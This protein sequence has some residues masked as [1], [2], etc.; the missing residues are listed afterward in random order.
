MLIGLTGGIASGKSTVTKLFMNEGIP[1]V[2]ADLIAREV[3]EVGREAWKKIVDYF[4]E[5]ILLP[6]K[7]INR[8]KLGNIIFQDENKRKKLNE[9][10]HPII[11]S[12]ILSRAK[13]LQ[14]TYKRVIVDIPLLFESRRESLFDLIIVVYVD[15]ESQIKRLMERDHIDRNEALSKINSQIPL[16][17]KIKWADIVIY[18]DKTIEET[19]KQVIDIIKK[20]NG[21]V[22]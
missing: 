12:E 7:S 10:T 19:K 3:V 22:G 17:D 13:K 11:I 5:E 4:G 14:V 6:D 21:K 16:D 2:D 8:K 9:I 15:K 1:V 18:N 20:I